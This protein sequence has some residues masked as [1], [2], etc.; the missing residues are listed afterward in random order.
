[1]DGFI[2]LV[3]EIT[4]SARN[5]GSAISEVNS[6]VATKIT[7]FLG[8][9]PCSIVCAVMSYRKLPHQA[10]GHPHW[11]WRRN[12]QTTKYN[13]PKEGCLVVNSVF[14]FHNSHTDSVPVTY[15]SQYAS[16]KFGVTCRELLTI[17][18]TY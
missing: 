15:P 10:A 9:T 14:K 5:I 12:V 8:T 1:L 2:F 13:I 4:V 6:E 11:R 16:G 18:R 17:V 7:A 3:D